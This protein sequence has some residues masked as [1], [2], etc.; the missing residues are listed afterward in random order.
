MR[1]LSSCLGN[2]DGPV[3]G[4]KLGRTVDGQFNGER[5]GAQGTEPRGSITS[6]VKCLY[7]HSVM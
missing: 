3:K 1:F 5:R 7:V 4:N 6:R 2:F